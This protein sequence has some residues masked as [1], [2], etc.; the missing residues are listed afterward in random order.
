MDNILSNYINDL[1][2]A[3]ESFESVASP[4]THKACYRFIYHIKTEGGIFFDQAA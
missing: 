2:Q 4:V 1:K 3:I